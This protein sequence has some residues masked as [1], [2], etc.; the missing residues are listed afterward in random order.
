MYA[1]LAAGRLDAVIGD[2]PI[3]MH[4]TRVIPGLRHAGGF[5]DP[6]GAYAIM[7]RKGNTALVTAINKVLAAMKRGG[8]L[9]HD[10]IRLT[11]IMP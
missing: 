9:G 3:A 7:V 8:T 1:A 6:D 4:F 5:P 10:P 2:A 11:R